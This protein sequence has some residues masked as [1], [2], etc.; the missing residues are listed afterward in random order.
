VIQHV[1]ANQWL[2]HMR[3]E[4]YT[5]EIKGDS[6]VTAFVAILRFKMEGK[7]FAQSC[8]IFRDSLADGTY[9]DL[10]IRLRFG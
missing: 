8:I 9:R 5:A 7:R 1:Q 4:T 2:L 3:N 10:L 6:T